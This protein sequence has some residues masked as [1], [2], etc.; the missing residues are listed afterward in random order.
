ML[1]LQ[2]WILLLVRLHWIKNETTKAVLNA[3]GYEPKNANIQKELR[4]WVGVV[5]KNIL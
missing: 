5:T 4:S 3:I 2:H 1:Q